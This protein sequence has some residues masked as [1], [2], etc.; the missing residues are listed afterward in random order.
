MGKHTTS[1]SA[2]LLLQAWGLA[3]AQTQRWDGVDKDRDG[4]GENA[5]LYRDIVLV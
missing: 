3:F 5:T 4:W 1:A 2:L